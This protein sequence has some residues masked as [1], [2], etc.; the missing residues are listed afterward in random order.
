[1][2]YPREGHGLREYRH[3]WDAAS[4]MLAWWDRWIR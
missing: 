4:R 1:V 3:R 2:H